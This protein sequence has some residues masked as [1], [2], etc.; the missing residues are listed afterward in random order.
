MDYS[1]FNGMT[2][3]V[4]ASKT[5]TSSSG[6]IQGSFYITASA[7]LEGQFYVFLNTTGANAPDYTT[8]SSL[9]QLLK[10]AS[11][12]PAPK[13]LACQF[14]DAGS[15]V[16][17]AFDSPTDSALITVNSWPCNNTISSC[18]NLTVDA[19]LSSGSGGR[20][21]QSV[22]WRVDGYTG[23]LTD[24]TSNTIYP[25]NVL[26]ILL[27]NGVK[28]NQLINSSSA[29]ASFKVTGNRNLPTLNI[30]GSSVV[31]VNPS[32]TVLVYSNAA[33]SS[34]SESQN[35]Q[36]SWT[37]FVAGGVDSGI[38]SVSSEPKVLIIA[39][40]SLRAGAI[41]QAQ[42]TA[43]VKVGETDN[44]ASA[45]MT[46]QVV[47]G[48]VVAAVR[49]GYNRAVF[50]TSTLLLDASSSTDANLP[51]IAASQGLTYKWTCSITSTVNYGN[52][53]A[54]TFGSQST[55]S[56]SVNLAGTLITYGVTYAFTVKVS[57]S[58]GRSDS[59]V[60]TVQNLVVPI[61][62]SPTPD[63]TSAPTF[64]GAY[65][66]ISS[67]YSKFNADSQVSIFGFVQATYP[68]TAQWT[69]QVSGSS[70]SFTSLTTQLKDF[71][72]DEATAKISFPLAI[73]GST[74]V[75]GSQITFRIGANMK[76]AT[77]TALYS[78]SEIV[79]TVNAPPSGGLISSAPLTGVPLTTTFALLTTGWS[80]DPSDYPLT[81]DFVY[82]IA[83]ALS[84]I[85][86]RST[87]SSA[88]T[89]LP[90]GLQSNAFRIAIYGRSY[91]SLLASANASVAVVVQATAA[92]SLNVTNYLTGGL[93]TA[94]AAGDTSSTIQIVN[95][96]A[97]TL[98]VVNCTGADNNTCS[99]FGRG[100]C[101]DVAHTCS[102]CFDG[103][104][105]LVGASNTKCFNISESTA[106]AVGGRC[107]KG[108]QCFYGLCTDG[109]CVE[110]TMKCPSSTTDV[111]S[112]NGNC[113]YT[114][115]S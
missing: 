5:F 55:T 98:N 40:H 7:L 74:F 13:L 37:I 59:K 42:V 75:A 110:P 82:A 14:S 93:A 50:I 95:N 101:I 105:G 25:Y 67:A 63:A 2:A 77:S 104:L 96:V 53:C 8:T 99:S 69:A 97:N 31:T 60:V 38:T 15:F 106:V 45:L 103:F 80:D 52:D 113:K 84:S 4:P 3:V 86:A 85:K 76:D 108:D 57:A 17:I 21:W 87:S 46:I 22:D 51:L 18:T 88:S 35:I 28:I 16:Y 62:V 39:A 90:V 20:D 107:L 44:E 83:T 1:P 61:V 43:L 94:A 73:P 30:V 114:D 24:G 81:Y 68:V 9:F 34:C 47:N 102:D 89:N 41:Y 29:A 72:A 19:T 115:N 78:Y 12:I 70:V 6:S 56:S 54:S 66:F 27:R 71:T 65:T 11:P 49:G 112:G 10:S 36:Y 91:D 32:Q 33:L 23:S 109:I 58:G 100:Q 111:C 92:A 64:V 48:P 79:L 26:D